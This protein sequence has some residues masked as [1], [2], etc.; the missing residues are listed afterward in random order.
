MKKI[1]TALTVIGATWAFLLVS[2]DDFY[3]MELHQ[4]HPLDWKGF[5]IAGILMVAGLLLHW[6]G[7]N[8]YIEIRRKG[9]N[10]D[11][12]KVRG[13]VH[14]RRSSGVARRS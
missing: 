5:P 1:G 7:D 10:E 12:H 4:Y 8:F 2:T 9:R 11:M 13:Q 6:I 14:R 3:T